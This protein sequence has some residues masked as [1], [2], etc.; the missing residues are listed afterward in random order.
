[1]SENNNSNNTSAETNKKNPISSLINIAILAVAIYY[2]WQMPM[3]LMVI[4]GFGAVVLIHELGHFIAAKSVGIRVEEFAIGMGAVLAGLS[5]Q[6]KGLQLRVLP[7]IICD[8]KSNPKLVFT[9]PFL[10]GKGGETEYQVRLLPLG[11]FVKMLGQEDMGADQ[12]SDDPRSFGNKAIWQRAIVVSAGVFMNLVSGA[13]AFMVVFANGVELSPAIVGETIPG[14]PAE[15]AG[16][17]P[18]DKVLKINGETGSLM[19]FM[20]LTIASAFTSKDE[21]VV[22]SIERKDGTT[23]DIEISPK[24][25][26]EKGMKMLGIAPPETLTIDTIKSNTDAGM[27]AINKLANL[28]FEAGDTITHAN[29]QPISL[30][31]ELKQFFKQK[32]D[33]VA[34]EPVTFSVVK[35]NNTPTEAVIK[36]KL[37]GFDPEAGLPDLFNLYGM[38]PRI[39][40][41]SV[42]K[43]SPAETAE[44]KEGDIIIRAGSIG[45]P[46]AEDLRE[47]C[48]EYANKEMPVTVIRNESDGSIKEVEIKVIP[49]RKFSFVNILK[50][51]SSPA[52]IGISMGTDLSETV[53]ANS[54]EWIDEET[55]VDSKLPTDTTAM[56]RGAKIV[57]VNGTDIASWQDIYIQMQLARNS[58]CEI[59][60]IAPGSQE[61]QTIDVFIPQTNKW[62]T[63]TWQPDFGDFQQL[64]VKKL[65]EMFKG[66]SMAQSFSMG[67]DATNGFLTQT[68]MTIK[69]MLTGSVN[70]KAASGPIGILGM[71]YTIASTKPLE[72]YVYMMAMLSVCIAVFNFLPLPILDGGLMVLLV[73]EKFMGRPLSMKTQEIINYI[74]LALILTLFISV[75]YNDLLRVLGG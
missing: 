28:G 27:K 29:G 11:G 30:Y 34:P 10:G 55:S 9:L 7:T 16:L 47:T 44:I 6:E 19:N 72:Y 5:K 54:V 25:N 40:V 53:V 21:K 45:W 42:L 17:I 74:G 60:F 56:P 46:T 50:M 71:S 59:A 52:M 41:T 70:M 62:E 67:I 8:S 14:S 22:F 57:K 20:D 32:Q 35:A 61:I 12:V 64:P 69:G 37:I 58:K 49:K 2:I 4:V 15:Q 33:G 23:K 38:S 48:E 1:M 31:G 13:I 24:M 66:E 26:Q 63:V 51:K 75:T 43:D 65:E 3:I 73:V 39:S 18:G 36:P 68:Y